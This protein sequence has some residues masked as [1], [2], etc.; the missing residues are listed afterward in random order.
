MVRELKTM[1]WCDGCNARETYTEATWTAVVSVGDVS[2]L[3]ELCAACHGE[4]IGDLEIDLKTIGTPVDGPAPTRPGGRTEC[5]QCHKLYQ[6]QIL[7]DSHLRRAHHDTL[8]TALIL[9]Y[10]CE[11]CTERF[12]SET[13]LERH[14]RSPVHNPLASDERT[15]S[16]RCP[17]CGKSYG[18]PQG[19]SAHRRIV[20]PD[21][22]LAGRTVGA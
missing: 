13:S 7:H 5:S 2:R 9:P 19:L 21:E 1:V 18:G 20:H 3:L 14:E 15:K 17:E 10:A 4:Y 11:S 22:Y 16:I 6:T 12:R 8:A